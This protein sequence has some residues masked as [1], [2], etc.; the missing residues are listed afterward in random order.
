MD[1]QTQSCSRPPARPPAR[2]IPVTD[3]AAM[4]PAPGMFH[5][6]AGVRQ[7]AEWLCLAPSLQNANGSECWQWPV[8]LPPVPKPIQPQISPRTAPWACP[9]PRLFPQGPAPGK[10]QPKAADQA[11]DS[12][13]CPARTANVPAYLKLQAPIPNSPGYFCFVQR[14]QLLVAAHHI[15]NLHSILFAAKPAVRLVHQIGHQ[16]IRAFTL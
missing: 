7:F 14:R 5:P 3:V 11:H 13:H 8:S 15:P 2:K 12:G 4:R 9:A 6:A 10:P 1:A 16:H